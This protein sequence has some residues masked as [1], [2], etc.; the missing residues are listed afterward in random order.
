MSEDI[1]GLDGGAGEGNGSGAEGG[2]AAAAGGQEAGGSGAGTGEGNGGEHPK[3]HEVLPG[4]YKGH[5]ALDGVEGMEQLLKGYVD[6]KGLE[7]ATVVPGKDAS[8]EDKAKFFKALGVPDKH[9]DYAIDKVEVYEGMDV[10]G[11]IMPE[12]KQLFHQLKLNGVQA[13]GAF[14]GYMELEKAKFKAKQ[15]AKEK[16]RDKAI[17]TLKTEYGADFEKNKNIAN[18]ALKKFVKE[19]AFNRLKEKGFTADPDV[20]EIFY[21]VGKSTLDDSTLSGTGAKKKAERPKDAM[22]RSTFSFS[23]KKEG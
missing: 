21:Q 6:L 10:T 14:K 18:K 8:D 7:G 1:L 9:E 3:W 5:K 23:G 11:E 4:A 12:I 19:D 22:G 13:N 16:A 17:E 2:G 15:E 20:V